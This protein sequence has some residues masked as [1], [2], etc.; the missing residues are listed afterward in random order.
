M[1]TKIFLQS[2]LDRQISFEMLREISRSAQMN[3]LT[4]NID[5]PT[6][7]RGIGQK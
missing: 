3:K 2:D 1:K 7:L 4:H 6:N 5:R